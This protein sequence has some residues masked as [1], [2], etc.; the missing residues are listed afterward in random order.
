MSLCLVKCLI[1]CRLLASRLEFW[2]FS[3]WLRRW[4]GIDAKTRGAVVVKASVSWL[5]N[6]SPCKRVDLNNLATLFF[7]SFCQCH[8]KIKISDVLFL[9]LFFLIFHCKNVQAPQALTSALSSVL[10]ARWLGAKPL[11]E[12]SVLT[13]SFPPCLPSVWELP[14][15]PTLC[16]F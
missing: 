3:Y 13:E 5:K 8:F 2:L 4:L 6:H 11:E 15:P 16:K 10:C 1:N 12:D 14:T 9:W 7:L